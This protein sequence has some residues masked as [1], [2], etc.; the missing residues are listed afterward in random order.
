M[1]YA[2]LSTW[3]VPSFGRGLAECKASGYENV[4][5]FAKVINIKLVKNIKNLFH[6]RFHSARLDKEKVNLEPVM[7]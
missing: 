5:Q 6:Y 1:T 7:F 2:C 4:L 3:Q